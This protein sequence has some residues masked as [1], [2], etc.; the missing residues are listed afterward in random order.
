MK[1]NILTNQNDSIPPKIS[2]MKRCSMVKDKQLF[3][4]PW[5]M[6]EKQQNRILLYGLQQLETQPGEENWYCYWNTSQEEANESSEK[7][8]KLW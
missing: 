1:W 8:I 5:S 3:R 4:D 6:K 2:F 7:R